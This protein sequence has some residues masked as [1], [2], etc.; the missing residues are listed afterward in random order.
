MCNQERLYSIVIPE[1]ASVSEKYAATELQ[2]YMQQATSTKYDIVTE[3]ENV[4]LGGRYISVGKTKL[5]ESLD[6]SD[7]NVDG[8]RIKTE[9]KTVLIKGERDAGTL[10]GVYE[11]LEKFLGVKF[12]TAD[13]VYVPKFAKLAIPETD[14][15]E[16]P[17]FETR[18][19]HAQIAKTSQEGVVRMRFMPNPAFGDAT[20]KY[21]F[22]GVGFD[23]IGRYHSYNEYVP[24]GVYGKKHPEW[25]SAPNEVGKVQPSLANGLTDDGEIDETMDE[26]VLKTCIESVKAFILR[27]PL[28]RYVCLG[29]NDCHNWSMQEADVRQRELFGGYA[30]H[31]IVFVNAVAK[32]VDEW[33]KEEKIDRELKYWLFAYGGTVDP[34]EPTAI[35]AH[36]AVPRHNVYV[37]PALLEDAWNI[38]LNDKRNSR[39]CRVMPAWQ[40]ITKNFFMYDYTGNF[41]NTFHWRTLRVLKP[42]AL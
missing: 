40:R 4:K 26:S 39:P 33:L 27:N 41:N 28:G 37:M 16:I 25:F 5:A 30:G 7:L 8:F 20:P 29:Q 1:K 24:Y 34:P 32:A 23:H 12:L 15:T 35:K 21:R 10:F 13:Y 42:N 2:T 18:F 38:P 31:C 36:L 6:V 17:D 19:Y 9:G 11:F 22:G 3:D 14:M